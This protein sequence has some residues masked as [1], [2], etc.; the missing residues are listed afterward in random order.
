MKILLLALLVATA[1]SVNWNLPDSLPSCYTGLP[2]SFQLGAGYSYKSVDIPAWAAIDAQKGLLSGASDKSGAWPFTLDVSNGKDN[3]RKQYILNVID[4]KAAAGSIW[5]GQADNYYS[6]NVS[7]PFRVVASKT[8]KTYVNVGDKFTYAF[9]TE[10]QV[11]RPVWAFLNLPSGIVGDATTG[12]LLGTFTVPGIYTIGVESADQAGNTAEGF[13]T[14]TCGNGGIQSLNKVTVSNSVP[15]VYD[16]KAVQ[17]QQVAADKQLFS[18]LASVNDA[19]A[20]VSTR[21]GLYD[22]INIKL[23]AAEA[24][25]DKAAANA[26]KANTDRENSANRL[27]QTNKA[28]NDAEDKLNLALLYQAGA[29]SNVNK[30]DSNQKDAESK[31]N[32]AQKLLADAEKAL[33]TA[34]AVLNDKKLAETQASTL[35]R[36]AQKDYD[37]ANEDLNEAKNR[38]AAAKDALDKAEGDLTKAKNDLSL[39]SQAWDQADHQ[40]KEATIQLANAEAARQAALK[41]LQDATAANQKATTALGAAEWNLNQAVAALNVANAAKDA[42]DRTSALVIAN[43][44]PQ[45]NNQVDVKAVFSSCQNVDLPRYSGSVRVLK[46][47][48]DR[49]LLVTGNTILF[50]SCTAGRQTIQ[51]GSTVS[52][53]GAINPLS[54]CIEVYKAEAAVLI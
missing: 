28:L 42:A 14:V 19:K 11:G 53:W 40:L 48:T 43:G 13:I 17:D 39:A 29:Q 41:V 38:L 45:A 50:G 54:K 37:R 18:A 49:A 9:S 6:R 16:I 36:N 47:Y 34:Q 15:F 12:S 5:A 35:L 1:V 52:I 46:V 3:V 44:V 20:E 51:A 7:N 27:S 30:A 33:Q 8:D 31:F 4:S 25:A 10:N 24:A 22:G 21:Q 2:F 32:A 23:V 26:A